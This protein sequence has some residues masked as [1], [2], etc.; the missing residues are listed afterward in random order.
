MNTDTESYTTNDDRQS[1][2]SSLNANSNSDQY[3]D[4]VHSVLDTDNSNIMLDSEINQ[5]LKEIDDQNNSNNNNRNN[6][7]A[8]SNEDNSGENGRMMLDDVYYSLEYDYQDYSLK[9]LKESEREQR[10]TI[11]DQ[12]T[13]QMREDIYNTIQINKRLK[14]KRKSIETQQIN[15]QEVL[16]K[17]RQESALVAEYQRCLQI[18]EQQV[19]EYNAKK[20]S[21]DQ[22]KSILENQKQEYDKQKQHNDMLAQQHKNQLE[23]YDLYLAKHHQQQVELEKQYHIDLEKYQRLKKEQEQQQELEKQQQQLLIQQQQ[24][25]PQQ[26]QQQDSQEQQ[27]DSMIIDVKVE[28]SEGDD[29]KKQTTTNISE[30]ES[31]KQQQQQQQH[32]KRIRQPSINRV[33]SL[34]SDGS[35]PTQKK[36]MG[37]KYEG[38]ENLYDSLEQVLNQLKDHSEYSYPFL[39]KVKPSEAPNY[40]E[41]IKKPMD[42]SL[43]TKKLKKLEYTSKAEFQL[44]LNLIFTNCRM[45]NTDPSSR[46]Y[47][48]AA[49]EMERKS[50]DLMNQVK[51]MDFSKEMGKNSPTMSNS[52]DEQEISIVKPLPPIAPTKKGRSKKNASSKSS[53]TT[54]ITTPPLISTPS[55]ISSPLSPSLSTPTSPYTPL[56]VTLSPISTSNNSTSA[57]SSGSNSNQ[58]QQLPIPTPSPILTP[59]KPFISSPVLPP[60]QPPEMSELC[61]EFISIESDPEPP[62]PPIPPTAE[63][64][65]SEDHIT[66]LINNLSTQLTQ[67]PTEDQLDNE[68]EIGEKKLHD[69][70]EST[71][72][73]LEQQH[74]NTKDDANNQQEQDLL[75]EKEQEKSSKIIKYCNLTRDLRMKRLHHLIDQSLVPFSDHEAFI[76]TP[77]LMGSF[78]KQSNSNSSLISKPNCFTPLQLIDQ[79]FIDLNIGFFPE[80]THLSNSVPN[81]IPSHPIQPCKISLPQ[82]SLNN[83]N[84]SSSRIDQAQQQDDQQQEQ[85]QQQELSVDI[86]N[87]LLKKSI[88]KILK[89]GSPFQAIT[90]ETLLVLTDVVA[91]FICRMGKIFNRQYSNYGP[92]EVYRNPPTLLLNSLLSQVFG[93]SRGILLL[94]DYIKDYESNDF[95]PCFDLYDSSKSDDNDNDT[96]TDS[97]QGIQEATGKRSDMDKDGDAVMVSDKSGTSSSGSAGTVEE[98]IGLFGHAPSHVVEPADLSLFIDAKHLKKREQLKQQQHQQQLQQQ[99][100]LLQQQQQL[101]QQQLQQQL[102][103]QQQQINF[104]QQMQMQQAKQQQQQLQMQQG[105]PA[106]MQYQQQPMGTP[107]TQSQQPYAFNPLNNPLS[108]AINPL[109]NPLSPALNPQSNPVSPAAVNIKNTTTITPMGLVNTPNLL[110]VQTPLAPPSTT[111]TTTSTIIQ[112]PPAQI[113]SSPALTPISSTSSSAPTT[114]STTTSSSSSSSKKKKDREKDKEKEKEKEKVPKPKKPKKL[115]KK[116]EIAAKAAAAAAEASKESSVPVVTTPQQ[117]TTTVLTPT[118]HSQPPSSQIIYSNTIIGQPPPSFTSISEINPTLSTMSQISPSVSQTQ[119]SSTPT[120]TP[121]TL[122]PEPTTPGLPN[123]PEKKKRG[124]P[125][126]KQPA[127]NPQSE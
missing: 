92:N 22:Q 44:D 46:I 29:K 116:E 5:I 17:K 127:Q 65:E 102:Q 99:Q 125:H 67:I 1:L 52:T 53:A 2:P 70:Q 14:E 78:Y 56:N 40:Y 83:F 8:N 32:Q 119:P 66:E 80:I 26:Q 91:T 114:T 124:R 64:Q 55:T 28:S 31:K 62:Q 126:K 120:G 100:Q 112:P 101:Q 12:E 24:E 81:T 60:P 113:G 34:L 98:R 30:E 6:S 4:I 117:P 57:S 3:G 79:Q 37:C 90:Q 84:S 39:A 103:L 69:L 38:Q 54:P 104:Q 68:I 47:V 109:N 10:R 23:Q 76:R 111:T 51:D 77:E 97:M 73:K 88:A 50:K 123:V 94:K 95:D 82:Y 35:K 72:S 106:P 74:S 19:K 25:Q 121:G 13:Q 86:V 42:L 36:W 15:Y 41:I 107:Q 122:H 48:E 85:E 63:I 89:S 87:I 11:V 16:M 61:M 9:R 96:H 7:D 43:M 21:I 33:L 45:Y 115:T 27:Q 58:Q 49:N 18:Y 20:S 110:S 105:K 71:T 59:P 75:Q 118:L 93:N 108:P